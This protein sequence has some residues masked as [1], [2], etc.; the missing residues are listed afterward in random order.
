MTV[1]RYVQ[2]VSLDG[3]LVSEETAASRGYF[4][5]VRAQWSG[6]VDRFISVG[7]R[8]D[9]GG[10]LNALILKGDYVEAAAAVDRAVTD[11]FLHFLLYGLTTKAG[12]L[13]ALSEVQLSQALSLLEETP[14]WAEV[15]KPWFRAG[16]SPPADVE[17]Q[18][19]DLPNHQRRMLLFALAQRHPESAEAYLKLT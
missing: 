17:L 19:V 13:L 2:G 3:A 16:A 12:G 9:G 8:M 11:P 1:D 15:I 14:S 5:G 7:G 10:A 6:D 4:A 18:R